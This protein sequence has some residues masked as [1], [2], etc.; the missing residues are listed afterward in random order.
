MNRPCHRTKKKGR[1]VLKWI[2]RQLVCMVDGMICARR[3]RHDFIHVSMVLRRFEYP[4]DG[5]PAQ[6][7]SN[8]NYEH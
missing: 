8:L 4:G 7:T 2:C 3:G 1:D 6:P 5:T